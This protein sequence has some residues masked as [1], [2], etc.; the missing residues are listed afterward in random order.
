MDSWMKD[1]AF[2]LKVKYLI[3]RIRGINLILERCWSLRGQELE[4]RL[5][6]NGSGVVR[7]DEWGVSVTQLFQWS[8]C[9]PPIYPENLLFHLNENR[10]MS[11]LL[12]VQG[13]GIWE[14]RRCWTGEVVLHVVC[15]RDLTQFPPLESAC[16]V[17]EMYTYGCSRCWVWVV[18]TPASV[19]V[20][21]LGCPLCRICWL[22]V[23]LWG[24]MFNSGGQM[25]DLVQPHTHQSSCRGSSR[26]S[27][28][29]RVSLVSQHNG[30]NEGD[31]HEIHV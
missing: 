7:A 2:K 30:W 17:V 14:E 25:G 13:F 27:S 22:N 16:K 6:C 11:R 10:R 28:C 1:I 5:V 20:S 9:E 24:L 8:S 15:W 19:L 21:W 12:G 31:A 26:R 4:K 3:R 23:H 18:A 29:L